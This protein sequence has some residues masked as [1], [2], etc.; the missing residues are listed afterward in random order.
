M[1][2]WLKGPMQL[3]RRSA[4]L[5]SLFANAVNFVSKTWYFL[6]FKTHQLRFSTGCSILRSNYLHIQT[7][8][9]IQ[10]ITELYEEPLLRSKLYSKS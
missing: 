6:L 1:S 5:I 9:G 3:I 8:Y 7:K 10:F 2:A 4:K